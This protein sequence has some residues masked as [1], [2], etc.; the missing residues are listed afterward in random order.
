MRI[1]GLLP[2]VGTK[3]GTRLAVGM[4]QV[5]GDPKHGGGSNHKLGRPCGNDVGD[6][7][8]LSRLPASVE[9]IADIAGGG[10]GF[11]SCSRRARLSSVNAHACATSAP[12]CSK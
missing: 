7:R 6:R 9:V 12:F 5:A 2:D 3:L 11:P 1:G 4:D 10:Y 8:R